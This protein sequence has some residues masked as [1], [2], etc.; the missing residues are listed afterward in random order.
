[1]YARGAAG[2][3]NAEAAMQLDHAASAE[4]ERSVGHA[5]KHDFARGLSP[6]KQPD[7]HATTI[8]R[9]GRRRVG[10]TFRG[11]NGPVRRDVCAAVERPNRAS[12][13][14]CEPIQNHTISPSSASIAN[15]R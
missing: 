14:A 10:A 4:R 9:L 15:A 12:Y 13:S 8:Q 1:V 7:R 3:A 11:W 5:G 6:P 2:K